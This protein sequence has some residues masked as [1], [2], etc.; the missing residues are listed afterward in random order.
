M[1][2]FKGDFVRMTNESQWLQIKEI[3]INGFN[4]EN[5]T[6]TLSDGYVC[7][8]PVEKYIDEVRSENEH[9]EAIADEVREQEERAA[10][11]ADKSEET[12]YASDAIHHAEAAQY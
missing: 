10:P 2:L 7:P 6:M 5:N 3:H 8:A 4:P 9:Y 12:Y 11:T 1:I